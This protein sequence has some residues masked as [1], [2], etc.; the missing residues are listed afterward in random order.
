MI[1][2]AIPLFE[3]SEIEAIEWSFDAVVDHE[4]IPDWF[5]EL[6]ITF[7]EEGRLI[8]HGIY[9]SLLSGVWLPEQEKWLAQLRKLTEQYKFAH[10]TEHFGFVTGEDF[11]KGAPLWVPKHAK[12]LNLANDRLARIAE[13]CKCPVGIE[14]L[15]FSPNATAAKYHGYDLYMIAANINGFLILDLHNLYCQLSNFGWDWEDALANFPLPMVREVHISGGSWE[16]SDYMEPQGVRRDTHDNAVPIAVWDLLERVLPKLP[17][18]QFVILEQM[19]TAL[20]TE[21]EQTQYRA[22]FRKMKSIVKECGKP[23]EKQDSFAPTGIVPAS[24]PI[25]FRDI[26]HLQMELSDILERAETF[27]SLQASLKDSSK[28]MEFF[29]MEYWHPAMLE[30]AWKIAR[31]WKDGF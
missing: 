1:Q 17:N 3:Q 15:A 7:G 2:A 24:E 9:F 27:E 31:K 19:G 4:A 14:N 6:L 28:V 12:I 30:T 29:Q 8:G 25:E 22:D 10:I 21:T 26:Y 20:R 23:A 11:H 18:C 13:A 5:D 16:P